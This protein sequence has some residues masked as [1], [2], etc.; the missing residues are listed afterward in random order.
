[1]AGGQVV[2]TGKSGTNAYHGLLYEYVRNQMF[3]AKNYFAGP[4]QPAYKRNQFGGPL[5]GRIIRDKTFFFMNY[6]GLRFHQQLSALATVPTA[7]ML[8]GDF[9]SLLPA[10]Q[11]K[12]PFTG[13][14]IPG[15]LISSLPQWNSPAATIGK[16]LAGYYPAPTRATAAGA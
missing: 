11:L 8:N 6:E 1:D 13:A 15:N 9:S 3:D 10:T 14:S 16:A 7:V 4:T 12:N 5:G 2:V